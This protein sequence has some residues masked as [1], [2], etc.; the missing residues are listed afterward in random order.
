MVQS[1]VR[2]IFHSDWSPWRG[3]GQYYNALTKAIIGLF[4]T[5]VIRRGDPWSNIDAVDYAIL[6]RVDWFNHHRL[7]E[8]IGNIL[9]A[10]LE[11]AYYR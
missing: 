5:E 7:L 3:G 1:M 8:T 9:T 4:K 11:Q 6:E 2:D 10:D